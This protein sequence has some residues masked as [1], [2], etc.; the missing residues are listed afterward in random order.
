MKPLQKKELFTLDRPLASWIKTAEF[1]LV[2]LKEKFTR[3]NMWSALVGWPLLSFTFRSLESYSC[4]ILFG[5]HSANFPSPIHLI[6][7]SAW[8]KIAQYWCHIRYRYP[9]L[10]RDSTLCLKIIIEGSFGT[11]SVLLLWDVY[12]SNRSQGWNFLTICP[13]HTAGLE[14]KY[15]Q[16]FLSSPAWPSL[17]LYGLVY[18]VN[19]IQFTLN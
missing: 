13:R 5:T 7:Y 6:P 18:A 14:P 11:G 16:S 2:P 9:R 4:K 15:R 1:L 19:L 10:H 8:S 3:Q 17:H 12:K